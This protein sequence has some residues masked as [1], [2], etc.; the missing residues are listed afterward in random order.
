MATGAPPRLPVM[1]HLAK[2]LAAER[3]SPLT[4]ARKAVFLTLGAQY[5]VGVKGGTTAKANHLRG[6][7]K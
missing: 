1:G 2:E 3:N 5:P 7:Q 4:H 6:A